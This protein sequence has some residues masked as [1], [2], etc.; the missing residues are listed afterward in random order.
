MHAIRTFDLTCVDVQWRRSVI[1]LN[2][3]F[4]HQELIQVHLEDSDRELA[5][6]MLRQDKKNTFS[7]NICVGM[8]IK[9]Q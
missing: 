5:Q 2:P 4:M 7:G 3:L 6:S 8:F 9:I 1:E